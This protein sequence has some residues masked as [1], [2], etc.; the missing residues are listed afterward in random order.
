MKE[1]HRQS[2]S[3]DP[4][5]EFVKVACKADVD[6]MRALVS[7]GLNLKDRDYD[8]NTVLERLIDALDYEPDAPKYDI[9]KEALRLG[10]DP[11]QLST[12]GLGSLF[13]AVVC[14]DTEMLRILLDAGADPNLDGID[15]EAESLYDWAMFDYRFEVWNLEFPDDPTE[16]EWS[17]EASKL[18]FMDRLAIMHGKRRPD[19]LQLLRERG[20]LS[21]EEIRERGQRFELRLSEKRLLAAPD[22]DGQVSLFPEIWIDG[23]HLD[24]PHPIDLPL[25]VQS[26]HESSSYDI[27]TCNCGNALCAGIPEG[28][29]V[30]HNGVGIRWSLKR[31]Q[32]AGSLVDPAY[33]DWEKSSVSVEYTFLRGQMIQAVDACL[34]RMRTLVL[35]NSNGYYWPV[36]RFDAPT[37]MLIE[38]GH[39][40]CLR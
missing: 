28:V 25:L 38:A 5:R 14:M 20:A 36:Y 19:H 13:A 27:F 3:A 6:Q 16:A 23:Q 17:D 26:L 35:A 2:E 22:R 30:R 11:R 15:D 24:E 12:F 21:M 8:S 10:A 33:S 18:A 7:A 31:P 1:I 9:V 37:L 34:D 4:I 40:F 29:E 39:P 32:S